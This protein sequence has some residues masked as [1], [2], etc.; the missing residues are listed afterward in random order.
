MKLPFT[1]GCVCGEVRYECNSRPLMM[2]KCHCRDCQQVSGGAYTPVVIV[3]LKAFKITRGAL[4]HYATPSLAMG[5]TCAASAPKCG[6][7][8]TIRKAESSV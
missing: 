2:L 5:T 7:R 6:S 3:P 8:L 4:Q 1:G